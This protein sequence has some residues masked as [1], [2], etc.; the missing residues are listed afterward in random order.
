MRAKHFK[1][2]TLN[3]D[4]S[5]D[6]RS[7]ELDHEVSMAKGDLYKIAKYAI[8]LHKILQNVSEEQGLEGWVQAKITKAADYIGSVKHHLEYQEQ[9]D[10]LNIDVIADEPTQAPEPEMVTI[11]PEESIKG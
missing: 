5:S 1:N 11:Q 4:L 6:T 3:E 9:G 2:K 7:M 10:E 8:E